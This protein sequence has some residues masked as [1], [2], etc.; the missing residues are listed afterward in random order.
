M[1]AKVMKCLGLFVMNMLMVFISAFSNHLFYQYYR[2]NMHVGCLA[3]LQAAVSRPMCVIGLTVNM[4][5]F[6]DIS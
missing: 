2:H 1:L 6:Y 3:V 5:Y 4:L